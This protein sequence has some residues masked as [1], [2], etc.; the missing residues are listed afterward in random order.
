MWPIG[1]NPTCTCVR[2]QPGSLQQRPG[3][4]PQAVNFVEGAL[5]QGDLTF[6]VLSI[7]GGRASND[8]D[9]IDPE[10]GLRQ[11]PNEPKAL[12]KT[13]PQNNTLPT[14]NRAPLR[15]FG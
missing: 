7:D 1:T 6:P 13:L 9:A 11:S 2:W 3:Q 14:I 4:V 10:P 15:T 8:P 12:R 5:E